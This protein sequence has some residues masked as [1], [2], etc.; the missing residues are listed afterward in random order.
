MPAAQSGGGGGGDTGVA[1]HSVDRGKATSVWLAVLL[2]DIREVRERSWVVDTHQM[3]SETFVKY[4]Q[5]GRGVQ[6]GHR[7]FLSLPPPPW[8]PVPLQEATEP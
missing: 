1:T 5:P 3:G 2:W 4:M 8:T 7:C 6:P